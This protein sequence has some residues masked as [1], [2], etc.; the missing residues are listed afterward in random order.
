MTAEDNKEE[1]SAEKDLQLFLKPE[2]QGL[3]QQLIRQLNKDLSMC[4]VNALIDEEFSPGEV[5]RR[6]KEILHGLVRDDFQAFL[7]LLYRVDV[8]QSKMSRS[9]DSS[10][11]DY[12]ERSTYELL[13][14][15]WQKVWIRNRIR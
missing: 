4:G 9:E 13:K 6:L 11:S 10:F 3:E 15:E 12:I 8:P 5:V 1:N 7:N 2:S 14:R